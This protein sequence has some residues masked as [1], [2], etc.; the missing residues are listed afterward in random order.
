[1]HLRPPN[2]ADGTE[3]SGETDTAAVAAMS[4]GEGKND[5]MA[6]AQ[7]KLAAGHQVGLM[8]KRNI[9][10]E[11]PDVQESFAN[12][13]WADSVVGPPSTWAPE[14]VSLHNARYLLRESGD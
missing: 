4:S 12:F 6:R 1:M 7:V 2:E 13:P 11:F 3:L 10:D 14:I 9:G 5:G 8:D